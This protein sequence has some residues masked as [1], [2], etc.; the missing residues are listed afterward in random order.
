MVNTPEKLVYK[1]PGMKI[2][3]VGAE[4]R[5]KQLFR[6]IKKEREREQN[7]GWYRWDFR[8]TLPSVKDNR[9]KYA[10]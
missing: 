1:R 7:A 6:I 3:C 8:A 10:N 9:I 5:Q 2:L 4:Y